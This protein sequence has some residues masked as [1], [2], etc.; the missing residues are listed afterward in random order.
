MN[1]ILN[2]KPTAEIWKD[3]TPTA[4]HFKQ[5]GGSLLT[6]D[7][8]VANPPFSDKAWSNGLDPHNDEFNRFEYGIPPAK[9]GDYAYLLHPSEIH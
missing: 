4:P 9:N 2:D 1:M 6:V 8:A 3:N 7:F 5:D